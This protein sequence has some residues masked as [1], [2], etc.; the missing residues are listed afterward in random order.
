MQS[1][2]VQSYYP[3][4]F[5]RDMAT[6]EAEWLSALPRAVGTCALSLAPGAA[7]VQIGDGWLDLR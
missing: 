2:L 7:R 6:T 1:F 5:E 3:E 4:H